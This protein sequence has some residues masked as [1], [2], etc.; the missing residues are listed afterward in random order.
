M[1]IEQVT[2]Q[3]RE[4]IIQQELANF[5]RETISEKIEKLVERAVKSYSEKYVKLLEQEQKRQQRIERL[6]LK[7]LLVKKD[8]KGRYWQLL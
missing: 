5:C 1:K 2:K 3:Q 8:K 7:A 4:K 6:R